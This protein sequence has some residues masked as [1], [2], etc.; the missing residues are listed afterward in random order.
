MQRVGAR[1]PARLIARFAERLQAQ[2]HPRAAWI[3][4]SWFAAL[5]RRD[6]EAL[7]L[8]GR[9]ATENRDAARA[10]AIC[11]EL[12]AASPDDTEALEVLGKL[13]IDGGE[14]QAA[15]AHFARRDGLV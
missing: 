13:Y 2:G 7:Y 12:L 9:F 8:L 5:R 3:A 10:R 15:L 6:T 4:A 11:E 1:A 14:L